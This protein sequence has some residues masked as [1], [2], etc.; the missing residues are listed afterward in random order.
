MSNFIVAKQIII[1]N[2]KSMKTHIASHSYFNFVTVPK[3]ICEAGAS[4]RFAQELK[5]LNITKV[6]VVTDQGLINTGIVQPILTHLKTMVEVVVYTDVCV[7]PPENKVNE[8]IEFARQHHIDG[9][10]GLGG[11]SSMDTAK[12]IAVLTQSKQSIEDIY[13]IENIQ[14]KRLP[15]ILIPTT[16]GTGSEATTIAILTTPTHEKKGVVSNQLLP[17]IAILDAQTTVGLPAH[18]TAMTGVDAMVHAIESYTSILK[19]NPMTDALAL[20]A[21]QLLHANLEK[22]ITNGQ[23]IEARSAMLLGA[24]LGGIAIANAP[25]GAVHALAY[26]LGGH[27]H[28]PHGHSNSVVLPGVLRYNAPAAEK[29]YAEIARLLYPQHSLDC[30]DSDACN[31]FI[32]EMTA[33]VYRMPFSMKLSDSGIQESDLKLLA[34]DAM[35]VERLLQNNPRPMTYDAAYA[36]YQEIL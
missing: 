20:K 18:I 6:L 12:I 26:P 8:A 21:L 3:I 23:N 14:H 17:D 31:I 33:L 16:A 32:E 2:S 34:T 10:I 28:M 13:G 1:V 29:E 9:V 27:F 7:D 24:C 5:Q 22:V 11:G 19:K 35:K 36:I 25:V 15:L 4:Q 30:N